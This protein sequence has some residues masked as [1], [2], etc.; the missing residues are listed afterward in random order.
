MALYLWHC[1]GTGA[2]KWEWG[3]LPTSASPVVLTLKEYDWGQEGWEITHNGPVSVEQLSA[4][5]D[6]AISA[7]T[8]AD[9]YTVVVYENANFEGRQLTFAG[10]RTEGVVELDSHNMD[11]AINSYI[12]YSPPP[13]EPANLSATPG[14]GQVILTW[15]DPGDT[16]IDKY[17]LLAQ[18]LC[19]MIASDGAPGDWLG[20]SVAMD[21]DIAGIGA[22]LHNDP[23][24]GDGS[25]AAYVFTRESGVWW[26]KAKL[27]A[28]DGAAEDNFGFSVAV[29]DDTAVVGSWQDDDNG[30]DSGS[31]YMFTRPDTGWATTSET[32]KLTAANGAAN[33]RFGSSVAVDGATTVVGASKSGDNET[34][35]E[36]GSAYVLDTLDWTDIAGSGAETTSHTVTGLTGGV[37]YTL[38]VRAVNVSG[39]GPAAMVTTAPANKVAAPGRLGDVHRGRVRD[40][41]DG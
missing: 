11:D 10:P 40:E 15:D 7:L 21:G 34:G 5:H 16:T 24:A 6:D 39:N 38:A 30:L 25:G 8:V 9:G 27:T 28:S 29:E 23:T 14:D 31:V 19:K 22:R 13:A 4:E 18:D 37:Q 1:N 32:M 33:D 41:D 20:Y 2:Q 26:E 12:L 35:A 3:E 17:Q 36:S